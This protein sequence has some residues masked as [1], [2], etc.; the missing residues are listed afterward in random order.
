MPLQLPCCCIW[1]VQAP[2]S[3]GACSLLTA[4]WPSAA[5]EAKQHDQAGDNPRDF[6][7]DKVLKDIDEAVHKMAG[8][9]THTAKE[10]SSKVGSF[11]SRSGLQTCGSK[12]WAGRHCS[13]RALEGCCQQHLPARSCDRVL[14]HLQHCSSFACS[15]ANC[16]PLVQL[17]PLPAAS[18]RGKRCHKQHH[19][20]GR[21]CHKLV[22]AP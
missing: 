7:P 15:A 6:D 3:A 1:C 10:I 17:L 18:W 8:H 4:C 11:L 19:Q 22:G 14:V 20:V 12:L 13:E 9:A 21:L 16:A 5:V 2:I